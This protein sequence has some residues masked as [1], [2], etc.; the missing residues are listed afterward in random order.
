MGGRDGVPLE[1]R[2]QGER[3]TRKGEKEID[4]L[5]P[6]RRPSSRSRHGDAGSGE[7]AAR[8]VGHARQRGP[9]AS[10]WLARSFRS[11]LVRGPG[12]TTDRS[13]KPRG[14][15]ANE[16]LDTGRP[17]TEAVLS[18]NKCIGSA[19]PSAP[20]LGRVGRGTASVAA[21]RLRVVRHAQVQPEQGNDGAD[22]ALSLA[23]ARR[24]TALSVSAVRMA[25]AE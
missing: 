6:T 7:V 13:Q 11:H 9:R 3:L 2:G 4:G 1:P 16:E 10:D 8:D 14:E 19:L 17:I 15:A 12:P 20:T 5:T 21:R 24:N 18:T 22:Q 25:S 23:V